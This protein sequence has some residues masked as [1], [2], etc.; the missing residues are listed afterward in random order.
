MK[1]LISAAIAVVLGLGINNASAQSSAATDPSQQLA[2]KKT[3][4]IQEKISGL[5]QDQ[6][7]KI[8]GVE[9]EWAKGRTDA[10]SS[11]TD[12]AALKSKKAGLRTTRDTKIKAILTADQ[13]TQYQAM[14]KW[15][16]T[17]YQQKENNK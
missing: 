4:H 1:A 14:L 3:Q 10:E 16:R 17:G 15:D 7:T 6:L 13:Y 11:I 5:T 9:Q 8:L 12:P 2:A